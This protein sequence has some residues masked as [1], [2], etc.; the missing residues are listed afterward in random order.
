MY[1]LVVWHSLAGPRFPIENA[2]N[3]HVGREVDLMNKT[4]M[5]QCQIFSNVCE[6][7]GNGTR[8]DDVANEIMMT[9]HDIAC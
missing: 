1:L 7:F 3:K 6:L 8:F 4:I 9:R 2:K 5:I